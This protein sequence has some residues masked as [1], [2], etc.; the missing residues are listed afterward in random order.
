MKV[1]AF[2]M[3]DLKAHGVKIGVTGYLKKGSN[4][5]MGYFISNMVHITDKC[6]P[7]LAR[8]LEMYLPKY[9][10]PY[11]PDSLVGPTVCDAIMGEI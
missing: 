1:K 7:A 6:D 11:D 3:I 9:E 4:C 5:K 10:D 8:E 2:Q